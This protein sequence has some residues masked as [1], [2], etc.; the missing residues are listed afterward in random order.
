V[1]ADAAGTRHGRVVELATHSLL[2]RRAHRLGRVPCWLLITGQWCGHGCGWPVEVRCTNDSTTGLQHRQQHKGAQRR[3]LASAVVGDTRNKG[4]AVVKFHQSTSPPQ[5]TINCGNSQHFHTQNHQTRYRTESPSQR[6][7]GGVEGGR[8][9][10]RQSHVLSL[11]VAA[12]PTKRAAIEC[13]RDHT[14]P[15]RSQ[16]ER[17]LADVTASATQALRLRAPRTSR[18]QCHQ[19]CK[20]KCAVSTWCTAVSFKMCCG[21]HVQFFWLLSRCSAILHTTFV[22][23]HLALRCEPHQQ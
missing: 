21:V 17:E 4:G 9:H 7:Q 13:G 20:I 10:D 8:S 12:S 3:S 11:L 5:Q 6:R 14:T 1:R 18:E 2:E 16:H 15:R 22:S 19:V 23:S